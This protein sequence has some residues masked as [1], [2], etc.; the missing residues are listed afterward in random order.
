MPAL[1]EFREKPAR[2]VFV[3][4]DIDERLVHRLTPEICR[5]RGESDEPITVYI[6]SRGGFTLCAEQIRALLATPDQ[7][8]CTCRTIT[9][10]TS[11]AD[12]AAAGLLALG[13]YAIAYPS[14]AIHC[15]GS[16]MSDEEIT[17][18]RAE[19]LA[20]SLKQSNDAFA[21][22]LARR[23]FGRMAFHFANL[24][25]EFD[26]IRE[27]AKEGKWERD[28]FTELECFAFAIYTRLSSDFG[29]LP[30]RAFF[31]HAR[32]VEMADIILKQDAQVPE[33]EPWVKTEAEMLKRLIDFELQ[34]K[35]DLGK[36][37]LGEG[38]IDELV[39]D[40]KSLTDYLF[41]PH[42][43]ALEEHLES[44]GIL[45]LK[46]DEFEQYYQLTEKNQDEAKQWLRDRAEP[47]VKPMWYFVVSLC[48]LLQSGEYGLNATDAYWLGIVD[49]VVG[50]R[51]PTLRLIAENPET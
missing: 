2:A 18:E 40:F 26:K 16:R 46:P 24:R 3:T 22:R 31:H 49:E 28:M 44:F 9:V 42:R 35:R 32:L 34:T 33:N 13:D 41:G 8:G 20:A 45:F 25:G 36:W 23:T 5:L 14:A 48:R 29:K 21:L 10:A 4:G 30:Q 38:G 6:N 43:A 1:A 19:L 27:Q 37:N 50:E 12:S 17:S 11:R 7:E 39:L 51:L 47:L 15:H